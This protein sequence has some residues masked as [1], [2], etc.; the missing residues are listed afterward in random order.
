MT[1]SVSYAQI[2]WIDFSQTNGGGVLIL[3]TLLLNSQLHIMSMK[4]NLRITLS[5]R[6]LIISG[7]KYSKL[8]KL[9]MSIWFKFN[10]GNNRC[11]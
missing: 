7:S 1:C 8:K 10:H 4:T 3:E 5:Q 2:L 6:R 11:T 9:T